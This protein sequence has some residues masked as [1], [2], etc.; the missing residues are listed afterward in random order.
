MGVQPLT[1]QSGLATSAPSSDTLAPT[2]TVTSP[3]NGGSVP[4]NTT[5]TI[6]GTAVDAGGGLVGGVEVSV[7]D[8]LTW[9]RATGRASWTFS[10]QTGAS[11][12]VSILSRAA[13]DSANLGQPQSATT[14]TVGT[15][16]DVTPPVIVQRVPAADA[17][18]APVTSVVTVTFN[19]AMDP[20]TISGASI[21]LRNSGG[22]LVPATVR[23]AAAT[24]TATL[25]PTAA[26]AYSSTYS[27][28]VRGSDG[29]VTDLA[30]NAL[31]SDAVWTF[32][33]VDWPTTGPGGPILVITSSA[34]LSTSPKS[35]GPR[36]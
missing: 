1:I 31:A 23:Y 30:G 26:L 34:S 2:S 25:E 15:V 29:G 32:T 8:G 24:R 11:R 17:V 12:T 4:E 33:T 20:A 3:A 10:W 28:R 16:A 6:A 21:E 9:R 35:C 13:D 18:A 36:D 5:V 27:V 22:A 14:V 7:D 19:E